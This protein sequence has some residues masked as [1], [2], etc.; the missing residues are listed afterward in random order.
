MWQKDGRIVLRRPLMSSCNN[1]T[2]KINRKDLISYLMSA[3]AM[4]EV[5]VHRTLSRTSKAQGIPV[6][7]LAE[8]H[9][10]NL[11]FVTKLMTPPEKLPI[12]Y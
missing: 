10:L 12:S 11:D 5:S 1:Q 3:W 7:D 8:R 9:V 4:D 6:D 2:S